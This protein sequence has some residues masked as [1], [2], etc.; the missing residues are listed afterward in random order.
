MDCARAGDTRAFRQVTERL[1]PQLVRFVSGYLRGDVDTANDI[2]QDTFVTAWHKLDRI[3]EGSHLRPW[4]Y[5][6]ARYKSISFLRRRGPRGTPME[7]MV[8]TRFAQRLLE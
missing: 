3:R 7:S 5:R 4:L 2:V 8:A 6:V 1:A